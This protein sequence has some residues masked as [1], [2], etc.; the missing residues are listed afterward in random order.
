MSTESRA[1]LVSDSFPAQ[2]VEQARQQPLSVP[3]PHGKALVFVPALASAALLWACFYPANCGWIA[4]I[5][6]V[7]LLCLVRTTAS[8]RWV[9]LAAWA[10]GLLCYVPVLQWLR[11]ADDRMVFTWAGLALYCSLFFPV[12]IFLVRQLDRHTRLPLAFTFPAV[13]TAL[14]Y[15]RAHFGTGFPWYFLGHSQH[16]FLA[17]IQ[18]A[19]LVG[20]Y[21]VTF[22]VAA[23]NAL[24]FE[25]LY[26]SYR[27]RAFL[28]L[29]EPVGGATIFPRM[30]SFLVVFLLTATLGYG[31]WRLGQGSFATG[32]R[33][34]LIQGNVPQS[35]RNAAAA[36]L[37]AVATDVVLH[38]TG[39]SDEAARQEPK[40]D[41]IVW[42]ETSYPRDWAEVSPELPADRIPAQWRRA[43]QE[44]QDLA[45]VVSDRWKTNVLLGLN[46][47]FLGADGQP[48][49]Y[50]S[51]VLIERGGHASGHY[52]K[53]HR[54]PF[55]EYVPLR[56]WLPWMN[57]FAPYDFDYSISPGQSLTH[58]SL[59][60]Y[61][62]GVVICYEDTDPYLARQYVGPDGTEPP[63]DFLLNIS[64]DGWFD[65]TSEHEQHLAICRFRAVECRRAI[66]RAVNMGIS[67]VID[68]NGRIVALPGSSWASSKKIAAVLTAAIPIDQRSSLYARWGDWLPWVC[69]LLVAGGLAG[70]MVWPRR[71]PVHATSAGVSAN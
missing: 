64:N 1:P 4:W 7:G 6:L 54:V 12:T 10:S 62:F 8:A 44:N 15:F 70:R 42:P 35:I 27:F 71:V 61:H 26:Q 50:N 45:Q 47:A 34:A 3:P 49:S 22:L 67:A 14:E 59:G 24:I 65:G 68:G 5:A 48:R 9:Y 16:E 60:G 20:A 40:P 53:I 58:F 33:V 56:N 51:A 2:R 37:E 29:R 31:F 25:W 36:D 17:V 38:Y 11:V 39:L 19:D 55:G 69:W 57:A 32:P 23:V 13:W 66:A 63:V 30:Q 43:E 18:I 28:S 46:R 52:D 21:A 41:L